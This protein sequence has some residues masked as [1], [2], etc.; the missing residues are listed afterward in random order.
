LLELAHLKVGDQV[1]VSVDSMSGVMRVASM[2]PMIT[3]EEAGKAM[4]KILEK[5]AELFRR[6]A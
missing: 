2:R 3:P 4:D 1:D 6:L 5:N